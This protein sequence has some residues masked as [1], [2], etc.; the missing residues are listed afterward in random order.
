MPGAHL[1]FQIKLFCFQSG[2]MIFVCQNSLL[3]SIS[4]CE[5]VKKQVSDLDFI[6]VRKEYGGR[7]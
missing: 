7:Q 3:A 2:K 5:S 4:N 6:G 1:W